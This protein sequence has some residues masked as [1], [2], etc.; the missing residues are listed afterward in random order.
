MLSILSA[1]ANYYSL[2]IIVWISSLCIQLGLTVLCYCSLS[3]RV[4]IYVKCLLSL[5]PDEG[6]WLWCI[7]AQSV[8][9]WLINCLFRCNQLFIVVMIILHCHVTSIPWHRAE[10]L[11]VECGCLVPIMCC[12]LTGLQAAAEFCKMKFS[13]GGLTPIIKREGGAGHIC[14]P[15]QNAPLRSKIRAETLRLFLNM[16]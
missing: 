13:T 10:F 14:P 1:V 7:D 11:M 5:C 3:S 9:H 15:W 6:H 2:F 16:T 4:H 12:I 8:M